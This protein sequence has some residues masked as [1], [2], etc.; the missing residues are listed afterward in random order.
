MVRNRPAVMRDVAA[1]GGNG[2]GG[3][4]HLVDLEYIDGWDHPAQESVLWEREVSPR[5]VSRL[6]LPRLDDPASRPD[7]PDRFAAYLDSIRWSSAAYLPAGGSTTPRLLSPWHSAVQVEDY[8]LYPVLKA[9]LMPRVNLLLADDVGLGKTIE[10]G[11][12]LTELI[13]RRRIRRILIVCPAALQRQ[14]HD[15][16][17]EKFGLECPV[18]DRDQAFRIQRELGM[19]ANPWTV[20][21]RAITSMDYLRQRDVMENFLASARRLA[22]PDGTALPWDVLVVD[23]A[24]NLAPA[25]FGDDSLRTRMLRDLAPHFEHRLFLTATPHNGYTLTFSGLLELLDPV[26]FAQTT[27]LTEGDHR[28]IQT[29]MVRRLKSELNAGTSPPRFP[30]REVKSLPLALSPNERTLYDALRAYR[31]AGLALIAGRPRRERNL[32]RFLFALLTKR[33]LSSSYTLARTWWEHVEGFAL[34][35]GSLEL[36]DVARERAEEPVTDDAE[37]DDRDVDAARQGAAWLRR[38]GDRLTAA[39]DAVGAALSRLGW[40]PDRMRD[41]FRP[42]APAPPDAK[43]DAFRNWLNQRLRANGKFR[44]DER[45]I[46][47]TEYKDTLAYLLWRV[48]GAG[49]DRP[50]L[51][52]L[53]GGAALDEREVVKEAFNDPASPLRVLLATDAASEG[54]NLQTSCRYVVHQEIPWNPMR[55]EQ[56]NGRVDR[57]NQA[58]DVFVFHFHTDE[59]ADLQFLSRVAQKVE[60]VREDLGSA[61]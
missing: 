13:A 56:R 42:Q 58:R 47:F 44:D 40:T 32:G 60:T 61:G 54:L 4:L 27:S 43:W 53:Y 5:V 19:D 24:H 29:V 35:E 49:I 59:D 38:F 31:D 57:H 8:Q 50:A 7:P 17:L 36:A 26:R 2:R 22:R 18:M 55:L 10:A 37:K 46:L 20:T 34:P 25:S 1:Y 21:P 11:L 3:V 30:A 52:E 41:P 48:R 28:Q 23:E 51:R 12:I 16:L 9:L 15:E 14:W 39:R 6:A 45:V 33:L